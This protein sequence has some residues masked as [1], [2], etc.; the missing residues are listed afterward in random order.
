MDSG[1]EDECDYDLIVPPTGRSTA[2]T[3]FKKLEGG[4]EEDDDDEQDE[5]DEGDS[6]DDDNDEYEVADKDVLQ[7]RFAFIRQQLADTRAQY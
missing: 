7:A 5:V 1:D 3:A 4:E 2:T 6:D